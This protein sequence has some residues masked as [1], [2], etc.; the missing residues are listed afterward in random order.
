MR[1]ERAG[2]DALDRATRDHAMVSFAFVRPGVLQIQITYD[3]AT[4]ISEEFKDQGEHYYGI[5][6]TPLAETLKIAGQITTL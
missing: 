3:P 4:E 5:W 1:I 6:E 2:R